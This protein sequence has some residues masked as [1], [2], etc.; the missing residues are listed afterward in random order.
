M[1]A[2]TLKEKAYIELRKSILTGELKP[3]DFLTERMLVEM[4]GMSRT[5]IRS[6]LERLDV[7]GLAKYTPNKGLVV[8]EVSLTQVI[9]FFDFR[10]AIEGHIA[11]RLASRAWGASDLAWFEDNLRLQLACVEANDHARFT[12]ADSAFH[13]KLAD[14]YDNSEIART[15]ERLQDMLYRMA[16]RVLRKD[17]NRI[18]SSYDDHRL[19]F[20]LIRD[21]RGAEAA[22]RMEEH[23]EY[24][25]RILLS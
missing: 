1:A 4:L 3:G 6:A 2:V 19:I 10:V 8:T 21:G 14:V 15:M 9:E 20:E 17:V 23:L 18:R 22:A 7:E 11:K 5:P 24:G 25:K 13:K 16:L 12:E